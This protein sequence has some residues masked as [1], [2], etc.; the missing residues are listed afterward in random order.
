[1][2]FV[3]KKYGHC[4]S[5]DSVQPWEIGRVN[6]NSLLIEYLSPN[7]AASALISEATYTRTLLSVVE[8]TNNRLKKLPGNI[9][10]FAEIVKLMLTNNLIDEISDISCLQNVEIIGLSHNRINLIDNVTFNDLPLLRK[11]DLSYNDIKTIEVNSFQGKGRTISRINLSSCKLTEYDVSN[12]I[13]NNTFC[14]LNLDANSLTQFS[15]NAGFKVDE[16]SEYGN[17][18]VLTLYDSNLLQFLNFTDLG[19]E[20]VDLYEHFYITVFM[21]GA[22][23]GCDCVLFQLFERGLTFIERTWYKRNNKCASPEILK[24]RLMGE[25]MDNYTLRDNMVCEVKKDC[26]KKCSCYDQPRFN[27][28]V[29]NCSNANITEFPQKVPWHAHYTLLLDGN[30]IQSVPNA[31]YLSRVSVVNLTNNDISYI[32]NDAV[33]SLEAGVNVDLTN[34]NNLKISST[35]AAKAGEGLILGDYITTCDCTESWILDWKTY[36]NNVNSTRVKCANYDGKDL[37]LVHQK[38]K[39]ACHVANISYV[40]ALCVIGF[41]VCLI[42]CIYLKYRPEALVLYATFLRQTLHRRMKYF[43]NDVYVCVD[44]SNTYARIWL[45][46]S[47]VPYL[48]SKGYRVYLPCRDDPFGE[49]LGSTRCDAI[50]KSHN[51]VILLTESSFGLSGK[52]KYDQPA[53]NIVEQ[54]FS[55]IWY[56]FKRNL[57]R[58]VVVINFDNLNTSDVANR[59]IMAFLRTRVYIDFCHRFQKVIHLTEQKLGPPLSKPFSLSE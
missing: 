34:N 8:H 9:C 59:H 11:L 42:T 58:N 24:G 23:I 21:K 7:G 19:F 18:G 44:D 15:N 43:E 29:I 10:S 54:E 51:F 41:L 13:F 55:H 22:N 40:Y 16:N 45:L 31:D 4:C 49:Y 35:L 56:S 2:Y 25:L 33:E 20:L 17:G 6:T 36:K 37:L 39:E 27:H 26:P 14:E 12:V 57:Y 28:L 3:G 50:D 46:K 5:C 52:A 48:E 30:Y 53:T 47:L 38:I 32:S 1:M